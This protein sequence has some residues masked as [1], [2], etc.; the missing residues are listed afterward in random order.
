L[1]ELFKGGE[2]E[3]EDVRSCCMTLRRIEDI[4]TW[5]RKQYIALC[6]EFALGETMELSQDRR[7]NY[8]YRV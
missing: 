4:G 7:M 3:E 5:K 6:G 2:D 8:R 1:E